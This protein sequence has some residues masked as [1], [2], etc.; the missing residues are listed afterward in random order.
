MHEEAQRYAEYLATTNQFE[1][2]TLGKYGNNLAASFRDRSQAGAVKDAIK[3]WYAKKKN[4]HDY[5][6]DSTHFGIGIAWSSFQKRWVVVSFYNRPNSIP[7]INDYDRHS[8]LRPWS[9][10]SAGSSG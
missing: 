10:Q 9:A 8:I 2:T 4:M 3:G 5:E 1:P 6:L 7:L